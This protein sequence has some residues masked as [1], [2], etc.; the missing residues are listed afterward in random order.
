MLSGTIFKDNLSVVYFWAISF[1]GRSF[2]GNMRRFYS[3]GEN[4]TYYN[5]GFNSFDTTKCL[6][7]AETLYG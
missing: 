6:S 5:A 7:E 1:S 3:A 2:S 4:S